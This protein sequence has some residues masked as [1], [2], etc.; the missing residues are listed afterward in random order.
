MELLHALLGDIN[1]T[2]VVAALRVMTR[3][4]TAFEQLAGELD[5]AGKDEAL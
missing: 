3:V 1:Q 4:S 2:E 5:D